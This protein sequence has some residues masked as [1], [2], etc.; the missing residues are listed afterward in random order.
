[1]YLIITIPLPPFPPVPGL[2][3]A[4]PPPLL[5]VPSLPKAPPPVPH[6]E[7]PPEGLEPPPPP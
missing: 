7:A 2:F 1:L 6:G 5:A 3:P 4:P